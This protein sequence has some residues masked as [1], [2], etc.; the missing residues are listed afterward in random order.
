MRDDICKHFNG[1]QNGKCE[2]GI[3]YENFRTPGLSML[4]TMPCFQRNEVEPC[5]KCQLPTAEEI[6]AYEAECELA[7]KNVLTLDG[8]I[9]EGKTQGSFPCHCGGTVQYVYRGSLA[10]QAKCDTCD[11]SMI[12]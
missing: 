9:S 1:I 7:L 12:S 11:W 6:K 5:A 10:A 8:L 2:A 3:P 4:N